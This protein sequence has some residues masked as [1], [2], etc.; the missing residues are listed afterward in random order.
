MDLMKS[1]EIEQIVIDHILNERDKFLNL[2]KIN[3]ED[4]NKIS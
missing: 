3:K 2:L 4:L 1:N